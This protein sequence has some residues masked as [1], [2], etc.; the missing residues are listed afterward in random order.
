MRE[1]GALRFDVRARTT[2]PKMTDETK[3]AAPTNVAIAT[4]VTN[5]L[6][7]NKGRWE[8]EGKVRQLAMSGM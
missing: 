4:K 5:A 7:E 3:T 8:D 2:A 1:M 6:A